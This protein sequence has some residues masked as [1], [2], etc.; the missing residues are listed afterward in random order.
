MVEKKTPLWAINRGTD[1]SGRR[2]NVGQLLVLTAFFLFCVKYIFDISSILRHNELLDTVLIVLTVSLPVLKIVFFQRYSLR[3][4]VLTATVALVVGIS[5]LRGG[6]Y[7]FLNGFL[8]A[9]AMQDVDIDKVARLSFRVKAALITL[10]VI[11]YIFVYITDP[12]SIRFVYRA[13]FGPPRHMFFMGHANLFTSYLIWTSLDYIY[14]S[15]KKPMVIRLIAVWL[16]NLVFYYFTGTYTGLLILI[17]TTVLITLDK[18]GKGFFDKTLTITA[19]YGFLFISLM[20]ALLTAVYTR[21]DGQLRLIWEA[22]DRFMTGR[23]WPGAYIYETYG[24]TILGQRLRVAPVFYWQGSWRDAFLPF[25]NYYLGNL[26]HFGIIHL[27]VITAA[28]IAVCG[29]ME[30]RDKVLIIAFSFYGI[31]QKEVVIVAVCFVLFIIGKYLYPLT[32]KDRENWN[33]GKN[34]NCETT[35]TPGGGIDPQK[36]T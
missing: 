13:G 12:S 1:I 3:R 33:T 24:F 22:I 18:L 4:L 20:F 5:C 8:F 11:A 27:V 6:N 31:M 21:L 34:E 32:A 35:E 36:N 16:V 23:M 14:L 9:L 2:D 25:D 26:Y 19:K 17:L 29:K 10:H 30:S 28:L 15:Y 7:L